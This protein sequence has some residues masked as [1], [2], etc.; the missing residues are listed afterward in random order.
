[1]ILDES[2]FV[3][4]QFQYDTM[5]RRRIFVKENIQ[6]LELL[7]EHLKTHRN[8]ILKPHFSKYENMLIKKRKQYEELSTLTKE[9]KH[10]I[11][12]IKTNYIPLP[13][14]LKYFISLFV[15]PLS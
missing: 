9:L 12:S 13:D 2:D 1:M 3:F 6:T 15:D 4:E 14:D 11:L 5:N 8:S 7:L 10:K